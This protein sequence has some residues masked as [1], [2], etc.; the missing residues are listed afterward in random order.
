MNLKAIAWA[1]VAALFLFFVFKVKPSAMISC[2]AWLPG[3]LSFLSE[4]QVK[5]LKKVYSPKFWLPVG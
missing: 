5:A 1:A 4:A 2:L 3:P